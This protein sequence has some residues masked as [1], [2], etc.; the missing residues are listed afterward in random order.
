MPAMRGS[1][2]CL[3]HDH[4][5][6]GEIARAGQGRKSRYQLEADRQ[7]REGQ[8]LYRA[9]RLR[10]GPNGRFVSGAWSVR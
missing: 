3:Q 7:K 9:S 8:R 6:L 2:Y 10:R 5:E 4:T 1:R